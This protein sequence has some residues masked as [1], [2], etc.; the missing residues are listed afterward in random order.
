[1]YSLFFR[2]ILRLFEVAH[3]PTTIYYMTKKTAKK[4]CQSL[5]HA[6]SRGEAAAQ[7]SAWVTGWW[8]EVVVWRDACRKLLIYRTC[9]TRVSSTH[10]SNP[11]Q[12]SGSGMVHCQRENCRVEV[13]LKSAAATKKVWNK[14][15]SIILQMDH[16]FSNVL[17]TDR[18]QVRE[19]EME[20]LQRFAK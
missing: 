13:L 10:S 14:S 7:Q 8:S 20:I 15:C 2:M 17:V 5:E 11:G 9:F 4:R 19:Q 3:I 16:S 6:M 12:H 18:F 1:M